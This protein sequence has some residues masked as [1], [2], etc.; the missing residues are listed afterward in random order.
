[1]K[2]ARAAADLSASELSYREHAFLVDK[3]AL[4]HPGFDAASLELLIPWALLVV[5]AC[6]LALFGVWKMRSVQVAGFVPDAA[7]R[8][9]NWRVATGL[10]LTG[11]ALRLWGIGVQPAD[12]QELTYLLQVVFPREV[13]ADPWLGALLTLFVPHMGSPHPPHYRLILMGFLGDAHDL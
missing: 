7:L 9:G 12:S 13:I 8:G 10:F 4:P 2:P 3:Q 5:G 11:L 1:M 6:T